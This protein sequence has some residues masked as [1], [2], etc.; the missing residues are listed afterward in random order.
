ML[1]LFNA[2]KKGGSHF[3]ASNYGALMFDSKVF[4]EAYIR[5]INLHSGTLR[6]IATI[7]Q[8]A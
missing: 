5:P 7:V 8:A 3:R 6:M 2:S 1:N 4:R